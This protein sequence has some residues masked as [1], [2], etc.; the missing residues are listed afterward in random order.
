[1]HFKY[2]KINEYYFQNSNFQNSFDPPLITSDEGEIINPN[3]EA[4]RED[5]NY[6]FD[7][8]IKPVQKTEWRGCESCWEK[9]TAAYPE[10]KIRL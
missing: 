4:R 6:D 9:F 7:A 5:P 10:Y 2:T 3:E 8:E 1:M